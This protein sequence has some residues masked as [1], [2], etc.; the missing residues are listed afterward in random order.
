MKTSPAWLRGKYNLFRIKLLRFV[1]KTQMINECDQEIE[2]RLLVSFLKDWCKTKITK[3]NS[4]K[5][6]MENIPLPAIVSCLIGD[7]LKSK[8]CVVM[9]SFLF[10]FFRIKVETVNYRFRK[11]IRN[12]VTCSICWSGIQNRFE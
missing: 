4:F 6:E 12:S 10:L 9:S 3:I 8:G 7:R 1:L 2:K 5:M 11:V